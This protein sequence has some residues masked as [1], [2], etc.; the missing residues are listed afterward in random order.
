MAVPA[1]AAT[2]TEAVGAAIAAGTALTPVAV[3]TIAPMVNSRRGIRALTGAPPRAHA[4][5]DWQG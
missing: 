4:A 5:A 2:D 1:V 3:A